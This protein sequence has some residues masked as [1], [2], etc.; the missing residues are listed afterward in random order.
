MPKIALALSG[1]IDSAVAAVRLRQEG[2]EVLAVHLRL[3]DWQSGLGQVE[4]LARFLGLELRLVD[5]R[6]EFRTEILEYFATSYRQGQTPNPCVRCNER[7]KFGRLWQQVRDWGCT[8]LAT[9]H[10]ARVGRTDRGEWGL[11][12][13]RDHQKDQSYFLHRLPRALLP[14]LLF[15][16]G[17]WTKSRVQELGQELGLT[18]RVALRESQELCFLERRDYRDFLLAAGVAQEQKPGWFVNLEGQPLGPHRGLACYTVGQ[19]R[20]L[21]LCGREPYYVVQLRP[22]ANEVVVGPKEA[23]LTR[24]LV[25]QEV[26]WLIP[27]P[28]EPITAV[29][30]VRYRHRGV[31]SLITPLPENQVQVEFQE[32]QGAVAPGQAA[33]F[34]DGDRVLGGGWIRTR[35]MVV[36]PQG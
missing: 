32:P 9:G 8:H 14:H 35:L 5:L 21:G 22:E 17:E 2:W 7:I 31:S 18:G 23:L 20:G 11:G 12:R 30:Q 26:N 36:E 25:A 3:T 10:Y 6:P 24:G 34:Y 28:Q 27:P 15:P 16:L 29:V 33:V 4:A 1:G 13:G 19:R